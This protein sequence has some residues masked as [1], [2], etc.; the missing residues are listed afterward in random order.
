MRAQLLH[1]DLV[2]PCFGSSYCCQ[3][4]R[5]SCKCYIRASD[6]GLYDSSSGGM[7]ASV[8]Y[9][10]TDLRHLRLKCA[11]CFASSMGQAQIL[12]T[13]PARTVVI[14]LSYRLAFSGSTFRCRWR[15]LCSYVR[16]VTACLEE[17]RDV[18]GSSVLQASHRIGKSFANLPSAPCITIR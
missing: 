16:G 17:S 6:P 14:I 10:R 13:E 5:K 4:C 7:Y 15:L 8:A 18:Q 2:I 3:R 11:R 9:L 12:L 1:P